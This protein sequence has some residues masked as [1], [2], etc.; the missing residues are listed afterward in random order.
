MCAV[1]PVR[2]T[3]KYHELDTQVNTMRRWSSEYRALDTTEKG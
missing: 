3:S 1:S 2:Y